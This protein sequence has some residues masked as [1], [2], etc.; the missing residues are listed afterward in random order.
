V[1]LQTTLLRLFFGLEV[2][3]GRRG[4]GAVNGGA[5]SS[6]ASGYYSSIDEEFKEFCED[7]KDK[8]MDEEE[9]QCNQNIIDVNNQ[10]IIRGARW[11]NRRANP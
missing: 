10:Q 2:G 7:D 11:N 8:M 6:I 3:C 1:P 4:C 9:T 5:A